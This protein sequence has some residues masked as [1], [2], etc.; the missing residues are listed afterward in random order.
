[1]LFQL[2]F[3][4]RQVMGIISYPTGRRTTNQMVQRKYLPL[5]SASYKKHSMELYYMKMIFVTFSKNL[6]R[7]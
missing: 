6:K 3:D 4:Q 1:M 2:F 5:V 7:R